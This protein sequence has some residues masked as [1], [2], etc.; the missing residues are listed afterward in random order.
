MHATMTANNQ[1]GLA[2]SSLLMWS[3]IIVVAALFIM[4]VIPAYVENRTIQHALEEISRKPEMQDAG[5]AEIKEAF[6]K[7]ATVNNISSVTPED[8]DIVKQE[9]RGPVLSVKYQA[10][11]PLVANVS[12]VF[13]FN[14]SS[15]RL[16]SSK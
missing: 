2:L 16:P 5:P 1:R 12:L 15:A 10:K 4:K 6:S 13:D 14:A 3:M 11:V 9:G 7:Y 8:L